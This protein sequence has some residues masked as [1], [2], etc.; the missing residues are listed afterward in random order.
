MGAVGVAVSYVAILAQLI[1]L[2]VKFT[3]DVASVGLLPSEQGKAELL[4][5]HTL[6]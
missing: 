1:F 6:F 2:N 5:L 4:V 3:A